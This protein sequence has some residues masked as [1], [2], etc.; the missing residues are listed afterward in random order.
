MGK[1]RCRPDTQSLTCEEEERW[2]G[3]DD[4]VDDDVVEEYEG[5]EQLATVTVVEDF[6]PAALLHELP[7]ALSPPP[8]SITKTKE[9]E[10]EKRSPEKKS[11]SNTKSRYQTKR[12]R[13]TERTKQR[14]RRTEKAERAGG[15]ASKG[16]KRR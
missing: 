2:T 4:A 11:N 12:Q 14:A 3:I 16:R 13:V 9:K 5:E 15:K 7:P 10:K 1:Y 6:D 8:L